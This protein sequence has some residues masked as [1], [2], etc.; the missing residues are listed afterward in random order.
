MYRRSGG[1]SHLPET[2]RRGV[3]TLRPLCYALGNLVRERRALPYTALIYG[4]YKETMPKPAQLVCQHLENISRDALE[5]YQKIIRR[6]VIRRQGVYALYSRGKLYYVGLAGDLRW[7]LNQHLKDRH[8]LSWDRFSVYLTIGE[9]H[10]RELESLL[11]RV[12]K[13]KPRGNEKSGKFAKSDDL[14]ARFKK[15]VSASL[16]KELDSLMGKTEEG[17]RVARKASA[18][19][20]KRRPLA[21][22]VKAPFR[23]QGR[24]KGKLFHGRVRR[25]GTIGLQGEVFSSPTG[26]AVAVTKYPVD[27]WWFWKY[28]RAPGDWVR[29]DELRK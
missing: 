6:Y 25:D 10:L 9:S 21:E 27:G 28:E 18:K 8:G 13:P 17:S 24:S 2:P 7:R 12:I 20:G 16:Q 4:R 15:D 1:P 29:L 19:G 3:S 22:Y 23:I 11:L 5:K 26:A 14:R